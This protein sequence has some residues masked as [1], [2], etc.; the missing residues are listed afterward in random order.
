[1]RRNPALYEINT[2]H[3][4]HELALKHGRE[5]MR[6][7]EVPAKEWDGLRDLGFQFVWLMGVWK[8]SR[9]GIRIFQNEREY[10][11]FKALF[12]FAVPGW[13][14]EDL[15]GSPYSIAAYEPEPLIGGW[16]DLNRAREELNRRGM[17]LVL[18]FA[19]NHTAPDHPWVRKRPDYY[20][21][22]SEQDFRED[23]LAFTPVTHGGKPLYM[24]RGRDPYFLPWTDTVQL[25]YFNPEMRRALIG[26]LKRISRH[27]DGLRCDMAMLVLNDIFSNTWGWAM[28]HLTHNPPRTEFWTEARYELENFVLIAE[29]YWDTEWRLQE[30]GFD[31]VYD[32]RLYDRLK[33]SSAGDLLMHLGADTGF[34]KRLVRFVEN[35]D[36]PR[37]AQA[38]DEGRLFPSLVLLSTLP[39][40]RLFH[41]GQ[42]EGRKIKAPLQLRRSPS[43]GGDPE[44]RAM[45]DKVL[46]ISS[47]D[48]FHDGRWELKGVLPAGDQSSDNLIA[49][50]WKLGNTLKLVVVNLDGHVSQGRIPLT[51]EVGA[52]A[53]YILLDELSGMKY[54][55]SGED[56]TG[57]G[58]HVVL[59]GMRAHV[60]DIKPS[61]VGAGG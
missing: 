30:L 53:A 19:P 15:T 16:E 14:E 21:T 32:K 1:M 51:A 50:V 54:L 35:H 3:W 13:T 49:Y 29:A 12:D 36:E 55:R 25:N 23:D 61:K 39:G 47:Q 26:E 46:A 41:H 43:E 27:C 33:D 17:G 11:D 7:S 37:C 8:R 58:L 28:A 45:Y 59:E 22:G 10:R 56:M 38:F 60:F 52:E 20:I 2:L 34:Q 24:A 48:V 57:P 31:Y 5:R 40:M 42:L 9:E 44:I 6:L 18:D 4:L